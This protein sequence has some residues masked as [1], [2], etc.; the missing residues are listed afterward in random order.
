M[1][2]FDYDLL[3]VSACKGKKKRNKLY[4]KGIK[5]VISVHFTL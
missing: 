2:S 5:I 3:C 4:Q 1:I